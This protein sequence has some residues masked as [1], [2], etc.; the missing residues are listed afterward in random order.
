[1]SAL[2]KK[3]LHHPLIK[4]VRGEGLLLAIQLADPKYVQFAVKHAP[5]YGLILDYFLFCDD[6]IRIAP[7][8]TITS[9]E[10]L[11]ACRLLKEL[12]DD[13]ANNAKKK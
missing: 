7:P 13:T 9:D 1:M 8:L 2:L 11:L 6:A 3:E 12:L 5:E 4:Q 10:I